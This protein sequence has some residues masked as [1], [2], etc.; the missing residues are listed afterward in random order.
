MHKSW[1]KSAAKDNMMGGRFADHLSFKDS[2]QRLVR[3][4]NVLKNGNRRSFN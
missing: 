4:K 2:R 1:L 3:R